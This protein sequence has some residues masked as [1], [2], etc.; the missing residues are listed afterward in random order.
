LITIRFAQ[1]GD[2]FKQDEISMCASALPL[3]ERNKFYEDLLSNGHGEYS[4]LDEHMILIAQHLKRK[5]KLSN[6]KLVEVCNCKHTE[7][8]GMLDEEG[9]LPELCHPFFTT[10]LQYLR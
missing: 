6:V 9:D 5:K 1:C 8:E 4:T 7:A 2:S 10:R 3:F